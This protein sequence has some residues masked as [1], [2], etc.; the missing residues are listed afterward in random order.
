MI[1]QLNRDRLGPPYPYPPITEAVVEFRFDSQLDEPELAK[2]S[3]KLSR[4]YPNEQV[5]VAKGVKLDLDSSTVEFEDGGKIHRRT[6]VDENEIVIMGA[7]SLAI[8]QLAV[9]PSW[10]NFH[11]RIV[12][13][14]EIWRKVVGFRKITQ[15]G[16][17]FINRIDVPIDEEGKARH[18]D[19]LKLQILLPP[20]YP[21]NTGYSLSVQLPL[22][23]LK[24]VANVNSG[25]VNSPVP[26]H[27]S[28]VLDIDI[29][30]IVDVP[31][32]DDD[33]EPL[34]SDM[35]AEKNR[36]FESFITDAAR[37]RFFH[38][39]PLRQPGA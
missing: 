37:E 9:Y 35:R 18:E 13:D 32:R 14:R 17:R 25:A 28:F 10:D 34:L 6:N 38:E 23:D 16:M 20:E 39:H 27:A 30:R 21:H 11:R 36:L 5:Q 8:S 1:D 12:R 19:Y 22:Q 7:Q 3:A 31:Q 24:S 15:I 26:K 29:I 2:I 4:Y 33:I